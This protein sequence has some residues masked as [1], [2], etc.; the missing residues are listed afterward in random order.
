MRRVVRLSLA[1][2][3]CL[4]F[5]L[6][7]ASAALV[8]L[9]PGYRTIV[10]CNGAGL[11]RLT[12]SPDGEPVETSEHP[13]QPCPL[14]AVTAFPAGP[15]AHRVRLTRSHC[16]QRVSTPN[17]NPGPSIVLTRGASRAPPGPV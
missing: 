12:I 8:E 2:C 15:D 13:G 1:L 10:I 7:K 14:V 16:C 9:L 3:L 4:A 11:I 6:P 17:P 5:F